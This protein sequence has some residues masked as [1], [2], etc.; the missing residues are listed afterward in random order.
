MVI[1]HIKI[2][3]PAWSTDSGYANATLG[4]SAYFRTDT[5]VNSNFFTLGS[6]AYRGSSNWQHVNSGWATQLQQ[7]AH[8]GDL[9]YSSSSTSGS[10]DGTITWVEHF[11]VTSAEVV[12]GIG[13]V[14]G[15]MVMVEI[16]TITTGIFQ[17]FTFEVLVVL[18]SIHLLGRFRAG[19]DAD[20]TGA[21]IVIHHENDRGMA[22]QGGR[23]VSN[24][25][26]GAI[27]YGLDNLAR[28][29]HKFL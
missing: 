4:S 13:D 1:C 8:T 15:Q 23:S 22:L 21:Q 18:V 7:S 29:K 5:D 14:P 28:S 9:Y 25:S 12:N 17:N 24:R 2:Q 26:Y 16:L 11:R 3:P 27:K 10:A 20:N 6:N 19:S